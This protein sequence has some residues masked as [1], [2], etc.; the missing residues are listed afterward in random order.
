M[1]RRS[2][3]V[4][5]LAAALLAAAVAAQLWV[6]YSIH[7]H[8]PQAVAFDDTR[9]LEEGWDAAAGYVDETDVGL[10]TMPVELQV[11]ARSRQATLA[12][13]RANGA[14]AGAE[15][16]DLVEGS[17]WDDAETAA[18][19]VLPQAAAADLGLAVGDTLTVAGTTC[20]VKGIYR[21]WRLPGTHEIQAPAYGNFLPM[22]QEAAQTTLQVVVPLPG[23]TQEADRLYDLFKEQNLSPYGRSINLKNWSRLIGQLLWLELLLVL[24]VPVLCLTMRGVAALCR[25]ILPVLGAPAQPRRCWAATAL[26]ALAPVT[27]WALLL[28]QVQIP[29]EFLPDTNLFDWGHYSQIAQGVT[30]FAT[31]GFGFSPA[32]TQYLGALHLA[33]GLAVPVVVLGWLLTVPAACRARRGLAPCNREI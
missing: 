5:W 22:E 26:L 9:L 11:Q 33:A 2:R 10:C 16:L 19:V 3:N 14:F 28:A 13:C 29:G 24:L 1:K 27:A 12:F 23:D 15:G 4:W 31:G 6:I 7:A 17:F 8:L 30:M 21:P 18:A 25:L 20:T 32:T